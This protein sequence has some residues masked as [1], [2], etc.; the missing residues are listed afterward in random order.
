M[1]IKTLLAVTAATLSFAAAAQ[2]VETPG[3]TAPLT[4]AQI[5]RN[6]PPNAL[7]GAAVDKPVD[8]TSEGGMGIHVVKLAEGLSHPDGLVFLPDGKTMLITERTGKL[9]VVT[10]G[11]HHLAG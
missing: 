1:N 3:I 2:P 6:Y 11:V 4:P 9:R 10:D 5:L 7:T 8:L